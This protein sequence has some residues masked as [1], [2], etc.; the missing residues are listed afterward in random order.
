MSK[1]KAIFRDSG[2]PPETKRRILPPSFWSSVALTL[3][4]TSRFARVNESES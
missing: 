2:A 4:N 1:K 3:L